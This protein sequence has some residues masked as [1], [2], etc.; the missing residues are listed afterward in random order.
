MLPS[1]EARIPR[2]V[3]RA[4]TERYMRPRRESVYLARQC[5][6]ADDVV[7]AY[8]AL[9][10]DALTRLR[11]LSG[12][13]A[14]TW[15]SGLPLECECA[16]AVNQ[17]ECAHFGNIRASIRGTADGI[18]E[19]DERNE[20]ASGAKRARRERE[21]ERERK[22][23]RERESLGDLALHYRWCL[24]FSLSLSL[25]LSPFVSFSSVRLVLAFAI[26]PTLFPLFDGCRIWLARVFRDR[27]RRCFAKIIFHIPRS[28]PTAALSPFPP[29]S[30]SPPLSPQR[31]T[32]AI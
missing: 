27:P 5:W 20:N 24:R 21:T 22:R 26:E 11:R 9:D 8:D 30:P 7:R 10:G 12:S 25:S 19:L 28:R 17:W 3:H 14:V 15:V 13:R 2:Y 1:R 29:P 18:V 31:S 16:S 6:M 4:T 23:E 32:I